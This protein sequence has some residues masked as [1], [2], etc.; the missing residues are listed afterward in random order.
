MPQ[1]SS[2]RQTVRIGVEPRCKRTANLAPRQQI[3]GPMQ[4]GQ[5][6]DEVVAWH[7]GDWRGR[8]MP[9]LE[10]LHLH[11]GKTISQS[12]VNARYRHKKH[13]N[14]LPGS[15][16]QTSSQQSHDVSGFAGAGFP[17]VTDG[18][19]ITSDCQPKPG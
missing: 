13:N 6:L 2:W 9:V 17:N 3:R 14:I 4:P 12:I 19:V 7:S 11:A 10:A 16:K 15:N 18:F 5:L 1:V 8:R